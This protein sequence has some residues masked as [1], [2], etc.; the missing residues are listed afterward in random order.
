MGNNFVLK[1]TNY[2]TILENNRAKTEHFYNWIRVLNEHFVASLALTAS[3]N[4]DLL[5]YVR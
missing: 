3:V 2:V 4:V 1:R 5:R